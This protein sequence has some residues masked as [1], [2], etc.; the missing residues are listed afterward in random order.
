MKMRTAPKVVLICL[1]IV[2]LMMY[3]IYIKFSNKHVR[4]VREHCTIVICYTNI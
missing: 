2:N 4:V 3:A 1:A